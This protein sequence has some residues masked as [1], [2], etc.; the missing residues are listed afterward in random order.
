MCFAH[1]RTEVNDLFKCN[2]NP[3][4]GLGDME[5]TRNKMLNS[6]T[7]HCHPDLESA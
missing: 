4:R 6:F 7:C 2:E 1:P 5:H 3:L